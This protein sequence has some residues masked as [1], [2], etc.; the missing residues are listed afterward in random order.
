MRVEV[1]GGQETLGRTPLE[2]QMKVHEDFTIMVIHKGQAPG[3]L[4]S[5]DSYDLGLRW[6]PDFTS[7]NHV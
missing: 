4:V 5:I 7:T 1:S 6:C 3:G 2:L